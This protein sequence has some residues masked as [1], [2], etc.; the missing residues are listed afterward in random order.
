MGLRCPFT[1]LKEINLKGKCEAICSSLLICRPS[2]TPFRGV[3][4]HELTRNGE[5]WVNKCQI[6]KKLKNVLRLRNVKIAQSIGCISSITSF[7]NKSLSHMIHILYSQVQTD[8][9]SRV[10]EMGVLPVHYNQI[11]SWAVLEYSLCT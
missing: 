6:I 2:P 7:Q 5:I 8:F 9:T 4:T 11:Q 3:L 10:H 1:G